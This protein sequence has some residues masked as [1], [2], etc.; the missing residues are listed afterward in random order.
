MTTLVIATRN[1]HKAREIRQVLGGDYQYL[2]LNDFPGAPDVT[3]DGATFAANASKK[4]SALAGWLAARSPLVLWKLASPDAA[5]CVLADD[6]GLEV[7]AL[8]GAPGVRSAR[9]AATEAGGAGNSPDSANNAKLLRLLEA[10]PVEKRSARFRCVLAVSRLTFPAPAGKAPTLPAP[11]TVFFEG[12]CEGRI[13]E[14]P[15]GAGGFGYDPLFVPCGHTQSFGEL[16][17]EVK[18]S[19]SHRAAALGKLR[20]WLAGNFGL[21]PSRGVVL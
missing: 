12:A 10:V 2:T 13:S 7:D 4:A 20:D 1:A 16:G 14:K 19:L 17:G 3:E 9:F 11:E 18:N 15:S 21:S 5:L 6:S 8:G